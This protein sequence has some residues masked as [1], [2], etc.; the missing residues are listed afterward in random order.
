MS[1]PAGAYDPK[2][3]T[4]AL[5]KVVIV[6]GM[7]IFRGEVKGGARGKLGVGIIRT[8]LLKIGGAVFL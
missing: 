6:R 1:G 4:K 2:R 7:P 8:G 3:G 5:V